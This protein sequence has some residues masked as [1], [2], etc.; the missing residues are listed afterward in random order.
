MKYF[1][2]VLIFVVSCAKNEPSWHGGKDSNS[3]G[4]RDDVGVWI[5]T[6]F[7]GNARLEM[8]MMKLASIDPASCD[9]KYHIKCLG[10]VSED[11][12][13]LQLSL[14]EKILDTDDRREAFNNRISHCPDIDDRNLNFK[15]DF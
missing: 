4:V 14:F 13:L 6:Q 12:L 8:A 1:F 5:K 7:S 3:D 2:I 15:C 9:Y 11:A 10:Q